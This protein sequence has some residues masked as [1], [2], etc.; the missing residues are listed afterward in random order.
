MQQNS[1]SAVVK[2]VTYHNE[3][4]GWSV[5]KVIPLGN[6]SSNSITVTVSQHKVFAGATMKFWGEWTVHPKFGRQFKAERQLEIRPASNEA[7]EK[8]L[9]SGLIYGLGPKTAEKIVN[10]F[11]KDA[12]DVFENKIERLREVEGIA[13]KKLKSIT[14][15]WKKHAQVREVMMFLQGHDI[16]TTLAIKIYKKYGDDSINVITDNPYTLVSD[17]W[18]IGFSKADQIAAKMGITGKNS[19]R[20]EAAI[21]YILDSSR[22]SGNCYLVSE[23]VIAG[24]NELLEM[25]IS[26]EILSLLDGLEQRGEFKVR[27]ISLEDRTLK[28]YYSK[29]LFYAED[30]VATKTR[31]LSSQK[32]SVD[33]EKVLSWIDN[34]SNSNSMILSSEQ[35]DSVA[36]S[37]S[38]GFAILTGGPGCGKT[39]V[40][41]AIV[42]LYSSMKKTIFLAAPTGRAAQRMEEVIGREAKTIHRLL[43]WDPAHKGF[44]YNADN[45]LECD[46]LIVDECSMLDI[47][48]TSSLLNAVNSKS[49]VL[50]I[51]DPDQLPSVGA[52][53]VLK[54]IIK[55]QSVPVFRLTEIFRQAQQSKI[56]QYAHQINKGLMPKIISPLE[57]PSVWKE[58]VDCH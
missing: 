44:K 53:N 38:C 14:Q 29:S 54:D 39:T 5:L 49:Q 2:R 21:K 25:E 45:L 46:V 51:G 15:A 8:Y 18:G 16:S 4:S 10:H 55:S 28:A 3:D 56:I 33:Q 13:R 27:E 42:E 41:K 32:I 22:G 6:S 57:R 34:Y 40:T 31:E 17:F 26:E 52:G 43:S 9:G 7:L 47:E 50:F 35:L 23:Q 48:L 58:E 37:S 30:Y 12:L 20:I 1:L 24:V 11:G 36:K 19:I